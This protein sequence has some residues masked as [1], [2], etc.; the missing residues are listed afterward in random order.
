MSVEQQSLVG[1]VLGGVLG[2]AE[3]NSNDGAAGEEPP[4][5]GLN[6]LRCDYKPRA[7]WSA[8]KRCENGKPIEPTSAVG[9][10]NEN[11]DSLG[12]E[13]RCKL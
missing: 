2:L 7:S 3:M 10:F 11:L 8:N 4:M 6:S 12:S 13:R 9:E 1:K 5:Q